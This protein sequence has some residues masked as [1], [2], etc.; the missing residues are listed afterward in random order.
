MDCLRSATATCTCRRFMGFDLLDGL[1]L[2][3]GSAALHAA[4]GALAAVLGEITDEAVHGAEVGGL[5]KS[6][7]LTALAH[8]TRMAQTREME[9]ER[10]G[11]QIELLTDGPHRQALRPR[12][13][14]QAVDGE[15]ALV[16]QGPQGADSSIRFHIS[17]II[18]I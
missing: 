13:H 18:E 4:V 15:A 2:G 6:A 17:S 8:Q 16:G 14:Q 5:I 7:A 3:D 1:S 9:R 10:G 12:L 11:S